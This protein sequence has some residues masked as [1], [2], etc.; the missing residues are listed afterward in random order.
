MDNNKG[1]ALALGSAA[2]FLGI[3]IGAGLYSEGQASA[4]RD[5]CE[6]VGGVYVS[7]TCIKQ[8]VILKLEND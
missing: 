3:A 2:I 4:R 7:R 8:E 5:T 1:A 6:F